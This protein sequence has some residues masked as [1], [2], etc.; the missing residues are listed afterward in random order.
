MLFGIIQCL[1]PTGHVIEATGQ[2]QWQWTYKHWRGGDHL[3]HCTSIMPGQLAK[4]SGLPRKLRP[5]QSISAYYTHSVY[6]LEG[7]DVITH[8]HVMAMLVRKTLLAVNTCTINNSSSVGF[9]CFRGWPREI[10]FHLSCSVL[11]GTR[12]QW[13]YDEGKKK[14]I[15]PRPS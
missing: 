15:R 14:W 3:R 12:G 2:S 10:S 13:A 7:R 1:A 8:I 6:S 4:R 5:Q 11:H 9:S